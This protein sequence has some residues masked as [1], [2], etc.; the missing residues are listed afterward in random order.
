LVRRSSDAQA[1]ITQDRPSTADQAPRA[2]IYFFLRSALMRAG[3]FSVI[4]T[5]CFCSPS[6]G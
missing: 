4:V 5:P 3:D 2:I 6:S 1:R